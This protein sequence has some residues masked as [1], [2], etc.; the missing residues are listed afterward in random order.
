MSAIYM[1]NYTI[2][3]VEKR[4]GRDLINGDDSY[5]VRTQEGQFIKK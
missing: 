4:G 3:G 5:G 2:C 1:H